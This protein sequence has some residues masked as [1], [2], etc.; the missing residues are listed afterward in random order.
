MQ[1][2][3]SSSTATWRRSTCSWRSVSS[4]EHRGLVWNQPE[5]RDDLHTPDPSICAISPRDRLMAPVY[6]WND[7]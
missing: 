4:P 7:R 5:E 2:A 1:R 3:N 6:R